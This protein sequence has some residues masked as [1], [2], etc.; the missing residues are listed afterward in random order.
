[1]GMEYHGPSNG[2]VG[3]EIELGMEIPTIKSWIL[4]VSQKQKEYDIDIY[5]SI[6][7]VLRVNTQGSTGISRSD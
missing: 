3:N 2:N 7:E 5:G 4:K 1:M 6:I